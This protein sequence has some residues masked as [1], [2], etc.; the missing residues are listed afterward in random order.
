MSSHKMFIG[1]ASGFNNDKAFDMMRLAGINMI[2]SGAPGY[3]ISRFIQGEP[4]SDSL[5][6]IKKRLRVVKERGFDLMG[7]T[8]NPKDFPSSAGEPGTKTFL[9]NYTRICRDIGK[10]FS[11][12]INYWQVANELDLPIFRGSMTVEQAADLLEAG[13]SGLQQVSSDF[14][15]G[16]NITLFPMA[17]KEEDGEF[18]L[19]RLY[20][21]RKL[22]LA[23]AGLDSYPGTWIKGGAESFDYFLDKFHELSGKPVIIQEFGYSSVGELMSAEE[24]KSGIYP[25]K[26]RKWRFVWKKEHSRQEQADFIEECFKIFFK[27]DYLLGV[28]YFRWDD[29]ER[30][31]Q[32]NRSDCPCETGWGL[33]DLNG[34]PKPSYHS[35]KKIVKEL[36]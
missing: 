23:Y 24:I 29:Q 3:D 13:I 11:G 31:W 36:F 30:C 5:E 16:I 17:P 25:C 20:R 28:I 2:R 21:E 1:V 14:K 32:C 7:I 12:L 4:Q 18:L 27:K 33:V 10:Q 9:N 6:E 22:N 26:I 35:F 19:K 15:I 34:D 8:P